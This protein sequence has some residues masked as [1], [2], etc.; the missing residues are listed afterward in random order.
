MRPGLNDVQ[1]DVF[2]RIYRIQPVSRNKTGHVVQLCGQLHAGRARAHDG[3]VE[4]SLLDRLGLG[5][6]LEHAVEQVFLETLCLL[7]AV[8]KKAM[9]MH[10]WNAEIIAQAAH[11]KYQRVVAETALGNDLFSLIVQG[12]RK[13]HLLALAIQ[14]DHAT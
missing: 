12:R 9:L 8:E 3:D 11:G 7:G 2:R 14:T 6:R 1:P 13:Q 10:A 5:M 4:L